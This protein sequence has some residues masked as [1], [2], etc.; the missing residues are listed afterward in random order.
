MAV[1][2][3]LWKIGSGRRSYE[4][5]YKAFV[6][7]LE[8]YDH[9]EDHELDN[10]RWISTSGTADQLHAD[11]FRKLNSD[12]RL[13]ITKLAAGSYQGWINHQVSKWIDSR[14]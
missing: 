8:R 6:D 1:Y 11:L 12:D 9:I 4:T 7:H 3:V 10:V 14:L 13:I 5:A 2:M